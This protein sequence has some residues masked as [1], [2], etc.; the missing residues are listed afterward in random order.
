MRARRKSASPWG[1]TDS[2]ELIH[3]G[4][5]QPAHSGRAAEE[6]R[7]ARDHERAH[8][9]LASLTRRIWQSRRAP[10]AIAPTDRTPLPV[11]DR[12]STSCSKRIRIDGS[13]TG[14]C[15][16]RDALLPYC[17]KIENP[18]LLAERRVRLFPGN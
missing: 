9:E 11:S 7:R 1:S 16:L 13:F 12:T 6:Q 2:V 15:G 17:I 14:F 8:R 3:A 4:R 5:S 10:V 18:A